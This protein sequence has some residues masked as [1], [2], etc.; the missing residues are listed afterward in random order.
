MTHRTDKNELK[1][2]F[3]SGSRPSQKQFEDLIDNCYNEDFSSFVSGYSVLTGYEM[4]TIA[5]V[6]YEAG[7]TFIIPSFERINVPNKRTYHYS[8]P[9]CNISGDHILE[10]VV[11]EFAIPESN[12]YKVKDKNK[13]V[14]IRQNVQVDLIAI[15]NGS[16]NI[17]SS[18]EPPEI[19]SPLEIE[20]GKRADHWFGIGI[21]ITISYDIT[22]DI[23]VSD[24]LDLAS[25]NG[26][27]LIHTFGM[28][29]CIFKNG[30]E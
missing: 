26:E 22:S 18:S 9:V 17:Y 8:I 10:K 13:E 28:A 19:T 1:R 12:R 24:Q 21:D 14:Q 6:R 27:M 29:G 7:K 5:S 25:E 4:S 15:F 2:Y 30:S 23:A 20:V 16:D 11:L 3:R